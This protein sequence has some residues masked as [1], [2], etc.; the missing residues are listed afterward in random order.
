[1]IALGLPALSRVVRLGGDWLVP[2]SDRH[3]PTGVIMRDLAEGIGGVLCTSAVR[4]SRTYRSGRICAEPGCTTILSIYN[5]GERC[6]EHEAGQIAPPP[7]HRLA[8]D[9]LADAS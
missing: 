1:V 9:R 5:P 3:E 8:H 4:R 2:G 6:A 7:H